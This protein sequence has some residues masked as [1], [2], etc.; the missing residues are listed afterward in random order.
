MKAKFAF[1]LAE[2][3]ITLGIIGIVSAMTL[4]TL[5]GKI[6]QVRTEALLKEDY[7]LL[8]Q[9]LKLAESQDASPD[10]IVDS[11]D[12]MKVWFDSVIMPNLKT[13]SVCY[14]TPGCWTSGD[15]YNLRGGLAI[16]NRTGIGI[17]GGIITFTLPNGSN[18]CMD[19]W[20]ESDMMNN[21]GIKTSGSS[22][23]IYIDTNGSKLPN[24]IGKDIY[25]LGWKDGNLVP[26]GTDVSLN[27]VNLNC[28]KYGS[29]SNAGYYCL[30][31]F[32]T[33]GWKVDT[34]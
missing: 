2:V 34:Y 1:T 17:G 16:S 8:Q 25:I 33:S 11:G 32:M 18:L 24:T 22:M 21:F 5:I 23:V 14:E 10:S 13:V 31:K 3:L 19:G 9:V 26:A 15:T 12:G 7:A 6:N 30:R 29:G 4:P 20:A 28:S 27:E